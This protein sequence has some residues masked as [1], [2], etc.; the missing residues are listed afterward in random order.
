MLPDTYYKQ[1]LEQLQ[2]RLSFLLEKKSH[3]AIS[4]FFVAAFLIAAIYFLWSH[5]L[6]LTVAATIILLTVFIRLVFADIDNKYAIQH[7][8]HLIKINEDELKALRHDYYHF[9]EGNEF[10]QAEHPYSNDLDIFGHASLFQYINR[11]TSEMGAATLASWLLNVA[12]VES[13]PERQVAIKELADKTKWKQELAAI[14]KEKGIHLYT[15]E[16]LKEWLSEPNSFEKFKPWTWL[17]YLLPGIILTVVILYFSD[18][19]SLQVFIYFLLA[20]MV[21]AY[22]IDRKVSPVHEQL[23]KMVG[24]LDVL[25][26]SIKLLEKTSFS[27]S[28]LLKM[29]QK[30]LSRNNKASAEL[31]KIKNILERL[32]LRY[33]LVLAGP[34]SILLLWSL[35]QI[36]SL[37]KWKDANRENVIEWF[38]ML[39]V[40]EALN[41]LAILN[42]NHPEW[43]FPVLHDKHFHIDGKQVG[44]PLIHKSKRVN[45]NIK[46]ERSGELMLVTGSNMA[47]KSTYLRSIGTNIVLA[48]A[49]AP[50]CADY[51]ILSPVTLVSSMRVADNLEESTST[52]YAELKKLKTI[53]DKVNNREKVFILLDEIL[54]GTNSLDRHTGSVALLKQLIR[55]DASGILATHDVELAKLKE[56][57][58]DNI[59]NYHFDAQVSN[60]EL[61][62]D[63]LLKP[64]ICTS[65]N[66]SIL[67]KK[68]GIDL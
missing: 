65:L 27:S 49:G 23:S 9:K 1:R 31:K 10:K 34:L 45:N 60:E 66:A 35:Q 40:F 16:R 57:Y 56:S 6:A 41:S 44:H 22:G 52:F 14:G 30:Y 12:D 50:V 11:T 53:I 2:K 63:Y 59:L 26:A 47:G 58:P 55:Q 3:L 28:L 42:F 62:F 38:D 29:Q 68:I 36:L 67:M 37:E 19:L 7:T 17:R 46:I 32:D 43:S 51:F 61:Y 21:I 48:M 20:F 5:G 64:G 13:I 4:R 54:R 8:R 18:E 15:K 39:G 33:N 25:S 24:E